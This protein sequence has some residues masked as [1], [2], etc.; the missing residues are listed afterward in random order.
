MALML[1]QHWGGH[2]QDRRSRDMRTA[3]RVRVSLD[4]L[5]RLL[6]LMLTGFLVWTLIVLLFAP[7]L[8]LVWSCWR[9]SISREVSLMILDRV[10]MFGSCGDMLDSRFLVISLSLDK[11][12]RASGIPKSLRE[13]LP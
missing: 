6:L 5:P 3:W 9:S 2:T 1:S 7:C 8:C 11:C 4:N 12:S 13:L 10:C